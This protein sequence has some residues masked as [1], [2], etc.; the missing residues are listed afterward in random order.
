MF[1]LFLPFEVSDI[2]HLG[3]KVCIPVKLAREVVRTA[4]R[5]TNPCY[6]CEEPR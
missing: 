5:G 2:E 6:E 3:G 4:R 1:P